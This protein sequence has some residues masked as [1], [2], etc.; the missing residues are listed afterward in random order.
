M[1]VYYQLL[2]YTILG[3]TCL[4]LDCKTLEKKLN[5]SENGKTVILVEN[6]EFFSI[7]DDKTDFT[8]GIVSRNLATP[9]NFVESRDNRNFMFFK[10]SRVTSDT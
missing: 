6:P 9:L 1:V 10:T 3:C 5:F 2:C 4:N 8:F 7:S